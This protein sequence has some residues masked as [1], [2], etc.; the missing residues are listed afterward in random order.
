M[1]EGMPAGIGW[2]SHYWLSDM[3]DSVTLRES[4]GGGDLDVLLY[5]RAGDPQSEPVFATPGGYVIKPDA[6]REYEGVSAVEAAT[7]RRTSHYTGRDVEKYDGM[8]VR[9]KYPISSGNTLVAGLRT[10]VFA[11]FDATPDYKGD[12]AVEPIKNAQLRKAGWVSL[13]AL[14]EHNPTGGSS[15]EGNSDNH[16]PIWTTHLEY[17]AAGVTALRNPNNMRMFGMDPEK[18]TSIRRAAEALEEF[19]VF[20]DD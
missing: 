20:Q 10:H 1:P 17:V 13:R 3:A 4:K 6:R 14:A 8:H 12:C 9:V 5:P 7:A 16:F 2:Y 18:F 11:R 15:G 19:P